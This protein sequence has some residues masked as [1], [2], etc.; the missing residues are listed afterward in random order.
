MAYD[1]SPTSY[2]ER[3]NYL[4]LFF[5]AV[6]ICECIIKII[7][8]GVGGYFFSGWNQFDFFVV[9]ASIVDVVMAQM[10]K[11]VLSFLRAGP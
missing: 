4:N 8:Y 6:F 7:A 9:C 11:Q 2:D 1:T 5:T 10:G 3:L